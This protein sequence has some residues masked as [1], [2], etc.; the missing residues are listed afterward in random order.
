MTSYYDILG[1]TNDATDTDIKKAYRALSLKYHPD[2]NPSEEAKDK[3]QKINEAYETL[4]DANLRKQYDSKDAVNDNSHF[5]SADQFNDINNIFNMMF[6]GMNG[7]HN[8]TGIPRVNIFQTGRPGQFHTQFHFS[9]RIEPIMKHAELI[10][11]QSYSGCIYPIDVTRTIITNNMEVSETETLHVNIPCG[12]SHGETIILHDSGNIVNSRKG[13]LHI[14]VTILKH[15]L[16]TRNGHDLIYNKT[17]SL[18]E[19]LC[20]FTI[21]INHVSGKRFAINNSTNPSV[22]VPQYK[23]TVQG[24]GM[25]RDNHVG[26][27]MI[28]FDVKFPESITREQI[29]I[30]KNVLT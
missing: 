24:L 22:I 20:G 27:L 14:Q 25:K 23:K 8:M 18:K 10:L 15:D 7:M 12:I 11:E 6:N 9:N 1:V 4:G 28:I 5:A 26:N 29:D 17:I 3:I 2:R 19:A 16:F 30:L 13:A 21:E